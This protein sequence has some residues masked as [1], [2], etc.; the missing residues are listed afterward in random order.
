MKVEPLN[1]DEDPRFDPRLTPRFDSPTS[2]TPFQGGLGADDPN[3]SG[4]RPQATLRAAP[5]MR[6]GT[7][8]GLR[9]A[10]RGPAVDV[11]GDVNKPKKKRRNRKVIGCNCKKS[12]CLKLYCDCFAKRVF[13]G[14]S[15]K[16]VECYNVDD[17][18]YIPS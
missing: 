11:G 18:R 6:Q 10:N 2:Q 7:F 14:P 8:T 13:C 1:E 4:T 17:D 3:Q 5:S 16:C 9:P 12:R 15:C